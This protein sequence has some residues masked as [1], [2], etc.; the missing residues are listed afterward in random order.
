MIVEFLVAC[1]LVPGADVKQALIELLTTVLEDYENDFAESEV[2]AMVTLRH[3]RVG[4]TNDDDS[5]TMR[6]YTIIGFAIE[7]SE[8]TASPEDVIDDLAKE[9]PN[10]EQG[11]HVLRFE[12][13]MLQTKLAEYSGEI[14][15]LEMKL[16][17]VLSIIYLHAYQENSPYDLLGLGIVQ[18]A[19]NPRPT[20][21][22]MRETNEN[23][24][25]HLLF[26]DYIKL[27]E[28]RTPSLDDVRSII[29]S[30][31][32]YDDFRNEILRT[33]VIN[34]PSDA[35]LLA[36]IK[37]NLQPIES[38][39]NCVAHYRRPSGRITANYHNARNELNE[40]LDN[41]LAE[42]EI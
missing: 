38:M 34:H 25:F 17:R 37:Q 5:G 41:Y 19:G 42:W 30:S 2:A 24:F 31:E 15:A 18:P 8:E 26:S 7:L 1:F 6:Q 10:T 9:L 39:R 21:S 13:P 16:R 4:E 3:Q 22:Q 36:E 35:D 14:F 33:N 11:I 32:N 28:R 20:E 40:R 23:Q 27:N 29:Q 12:D